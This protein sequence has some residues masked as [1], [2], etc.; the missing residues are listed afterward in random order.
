[1]CSNSCELLFMARFLRVKYPFD[2][3]SLSAGFAPFH[4]KAPVYG[5]NEPAFSRD[6]AVND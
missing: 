4:E 3:D 5:K 2:S 1:M 6:P